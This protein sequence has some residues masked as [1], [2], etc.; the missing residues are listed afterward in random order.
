MGNIPTCNSP[1]KCRAGTAGRAPG[2]GAQTES[3][4]PGL[5]QCCILEQGEDSAGLPP[6]TTTSGAGAQN[7]PAQNGQ[8][9]PFCQKREKA[10]ALITQLSLASSD[11]CFQ[12][13][14]RADLSLPGIHSLLRQTQRAKIHLLVPK[15]HRGH[16]RSLHRTS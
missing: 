5:W 6:G 1:G 3:G 10:Q 11:G 8:K 13:K 12:L 2:S 9:F 15:Q 4:N 7:L 14:I 16:S